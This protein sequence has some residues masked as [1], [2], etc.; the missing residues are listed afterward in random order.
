MQLLVFFCSCV[1]VCGHDDCRGGSLGLSCQLTQNSLCYYILC[2]PFLAYRIY[3]AVNFV[4]DL[5]GSCN[6]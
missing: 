6:E 1:T 2:R 5:M 3:V 4:A